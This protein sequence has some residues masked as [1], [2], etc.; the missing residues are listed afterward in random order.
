MAKAKTQ[1]DWS[2]MLEQARKNLQ[3]FGK[4]ASIWAKKGEK[5]LVKASKVGKL[6]LDI[7]GINLQKEKIYYEV[8]KKVSKLKSNVK[9]DIPGLD[10]YWKKIR[11]LEVK[12]RQKKKA[13]SEIK[14]T[15]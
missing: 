6:Q 4:E 5:G 15:G 2:K 10:A 12:A 14:K 1:K 8:G 7:A 3:K 11:D 13:L 9:S